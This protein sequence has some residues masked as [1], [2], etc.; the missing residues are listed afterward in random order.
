[1]PGRAGLTLSL[2]LGGRS[3]SSFWSFSQFSPGQPGPPGPA[4]PSPA[5]VVKVDINVKTAIMTMSGS[6]DTGPPGPPGAPRGPPAR[7]PGGPKLAFLR[8]F[9]RKWGFSVGN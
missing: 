9:T 3:R 4:Q 7:P 5:V 1:M 2:V 8:G 6:H